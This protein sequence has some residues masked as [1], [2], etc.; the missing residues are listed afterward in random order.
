MNFRKKT[1]NIT[2]VLYIILAMCILS[3]ISLT[4]YSL[5]NQKESLND[6][7][8]LQSL[9]KQDNGENSE[10]ALADIF[11]KQ[12]TTQAPP[13]E[14]TTQPPATRKQPETTAAPV[15]TVPPVT[16]PIPTEAAYYPEIEEEEVINPEQPT[17]SESP[18]YITPEE[19]IEESVEVMSVP[20]LYIKPLNGY[21]SKMHKPNTAEYSVA[22]NDYRTHTG[23]D[24]DSEIGANV[25]AIANG[26]ISEIRNDPL[27]GTTVVI[28]HADG[29]NSIYSNLQSS[30]P[31]YIKEGEQ[32]KVGEVIGGV[33]ETA[34]IEMAEVSHLHFEMM[35]DGE[36]V[37]PFDFIEF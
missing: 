16:A 14:T 17:L 23:I 28:S 18:A 19:E 34:L 37:D 35:K 3:I 12:T 26:F 30:L 11:R 21:V 4:V 31:Q 27:M 36:Y 2:K 15:T 32:V 6:G 33:G 9:Q 1:S 7:S 24:I 20:N 10:D 5:F 25:K 8:N 22:M 13:P 29:I